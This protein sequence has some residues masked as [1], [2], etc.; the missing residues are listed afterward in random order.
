MILPNEELLGESDERN[1]LS[2]MISIIRGN[3]SEFV[4]TEFDKL[5]VGEYCSLHSLLNQANIKVLIDGDLL[6][7]GIELIKWYAEAAG[8]NT[9]LPE[10]RYFVGYQQ[11]ENSTGYYGGFYHFGQGYRH[12]QAVGVVTV[13]GALSVEILPKWLSTLDLLRSYAHDSIHHATFR[14]YSLLTDN[15]LSK[16]G[17]PFFRYQYGINL[18]R[19]GRVPYSNRDDATSKTT[20]NLGTIMDGATDTVATVLVRQLYTEIGKPSMSSEIG[21]WLLKL[22]LGEHRPSFLR[23]LRQH[24]KGQFDMPKPAQIAYLYDA[25]RF[26]QYVNAKYDSFLSE[27]GSE[28]D[29]LHNLILSAM[30]TG[31]LDLFKN[32]FADLVGVKDAFELWF[33]NSEF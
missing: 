18:R 32:R 26:V 6:H 31:N 2:R 8:F 15:T 11:P 14:N 9:H 10:D 17:F 23:R 16:E 1:C 4:N 21:E 33:R 27:F 19:N 12:V 29:L 22:T 24:E 28:R 20:R 25:R 13:L 3:V 30:A 7:K 5:H